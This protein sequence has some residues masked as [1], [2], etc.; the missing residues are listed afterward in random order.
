[1]VKLSL[2]LIV[3]HALKTCEGILLDSPYKGHQLSFTALP[4]DGMYWPGVV[5]APT[6]LVPVSYIQN[7]D[8]EMVTYQPYTL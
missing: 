3:Y 5:P 8:L 6:L 7:K 1:M 2:C 4:V